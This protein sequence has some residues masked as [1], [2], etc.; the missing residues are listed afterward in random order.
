MV[1]MVTIITTVTTV[2]TLTTVTTVTTVYNHS[3][4]SNHSNLGNHNIYLEDLAGGATSQSPASLP[5][6]VHHTV[7]QTVHYY[8]K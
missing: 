2:I 3:N 4:H 6:P 1:T 8:H 7:Y 5:A